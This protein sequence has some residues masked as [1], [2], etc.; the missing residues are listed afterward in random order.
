LAEENSND[1]VLIS[2]KERAEDIMDA[3]SNRQTTTQ[4]L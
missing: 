2:V 3:Y 4:T 1:P